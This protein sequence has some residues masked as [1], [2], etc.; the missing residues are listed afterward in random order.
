VTSFKLGFP[1]GI[2]LRERLSH[3]LRTRHV[4]CLGD[5]VQDGPEIYIMQ[6]KRKSLAFSFQSVL[7]TVFFSMSI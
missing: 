7:T 2:A 3:F 4:E 1:S 5:V 6:Y